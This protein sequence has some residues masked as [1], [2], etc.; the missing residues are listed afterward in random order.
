MVCTSSIHAQVCLC[1][2]KEKKNLV[3]CQAPPTSIK[4]KETHWCEL[5][6][7]RVPPFAI[8]IWLE[9]VCGVKHT[10][11]HPVYMRVRVSARACAH[12][13]AKLHLRELMQS[14]P[15]PSPWSEDT[16]G[17]LSNS[18]HVG[19]R[20]RE[21]WQAWKRC[22][23]LHT[24]TGASQMLPYV[25]CTDAN[26]EAQCWLVFALKVATSLCLILSL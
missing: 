17:S 11:Q 25:L 14:Y 9:D 13:C 2:E 15:M 19:L 18:H 1:E 10:E 6:Q 22:C 8:F 12:V 3:G 20:Q 4:E 5:I 24:F 7:M 16:Y 26:A 21:F 23:M